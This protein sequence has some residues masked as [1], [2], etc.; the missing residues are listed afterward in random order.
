MEMTQAPSIRPQA[1]ELR[2]LVHT[3]GGLPVR[4]PQ[5]LIEGH[6]GLAAIAG[7]IGTLHRDRSIQP[8]HRL[9]AIPLEPEHD[10]ATLQPR[11]LVAGAY[12]RGQVLD[13]LATELY[14]TFV[15]QQFHPQHPN[16]AAD[17]ALATVGELDMLNEMRKWSPTRT[18]SPRSPLRCASSIR[19]RRQRSVRCSSCSASGCAS[20]PSSHSTLQGA[21]KPMSRCR[22]LPL[23]EIA[24]VGGLSPPRRPVTSFCMNLRTC[25][26]QTPAWLGMAVRGA[27][28]WPAAPV[29]VAGLWCARGLAR[30]RP[31]HPRHAAGDSRTDRKPADRVLRRPAP[32][33]VRRRLRHPRRHQP[34][35]GLRQS[36]LEGCLSA[37]RLRGH[38]MRPTAPA[39]GTPQGLILE[40]ARAA[41]GSS[42]LR[43]H[44]PPPA[45]RCHRQSVSLQTA[46]AAHRE[47]LGRRGV[48]GV[49]GGRLT[50][51]GGL[52]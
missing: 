31:S 21:G 9:G 4:D 5:P 43:A 6:P 11:P 34:W 28:S 8:V 7:V 51:R 42:C 46:T 1:R 19:P 40:S 14:Q 17:I 38:R 36:L 25:W 52:T 20:V 41:T 27:P 26:F 18:T 30:N 16:G 37:P 12:L 3:G 48:A 49:A 35:R 45:P 29:R 50:A 44:L 2:Q 13:C 47:L 33:A 10:P 32:A 22:W 24:A 23:V 15:H 39:R